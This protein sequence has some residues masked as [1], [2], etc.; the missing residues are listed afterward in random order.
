MKNKTL[1]LILSICAAVTV[2][3]P[4][5]ASAGTKKST[6]KESPS[7]AAQTSASSAKSNP[8]PIPFHGMATAI[9][10]KA[11]TFKIVG[12]EG[13]RVFK[14]TTTTKV[15]KAGKDATMADI[16]DSTEIS[17]AYWER[18]GGS[19]EA[20]TVKIGPVKA[21]KKESPAASASPKS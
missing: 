21:R 9:D 5:A 2:S 18:D 11:R 13:S 12:K 4:T 15:T 19:L 10:Q 6:A 14:V 17:G 3:L 7:P 16:T 1:L 20:K 8:R